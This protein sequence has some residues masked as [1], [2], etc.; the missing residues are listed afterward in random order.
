LADLFGFF[1]LT[2]GGGHE[3]YI[4]W[5]DV[6]VLYIVFVVGVYILNGIF[7]FNMVEYY[8]G[9]IGIWVICGGGVLCDTTLFDRSWIQTA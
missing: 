2:L 8:F 3:N 5:Y 7:F 9:G 6:V 1:A 4:V